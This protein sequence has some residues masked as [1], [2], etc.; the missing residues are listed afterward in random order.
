MTLLLHPGFHKTA[1]SWLQDVVFAE[2]R[3]FRSLM[4]HHEIDELL[5]RP[6]DLAF[7]AEAAKARIAGLR[8]GGQPGIVDVISSEILSGTMF[9]GSRES[10]RLADRLRAVA[11]DARILLTVRSQRSIMKSVYLQYVKRGGRMSIDEFLDYKPEPGYFWF[12]PSVLEFDRLAETYADRFGANNVIV[13]PQELLKSQQ[14]EYLG[15]LFQFA[16]VADL[17]QAKSITFGSERGVSPPAGGIRLMRAANI[18][19]RQPLNPE[20]LSSA[21]F[22]RRPFHKLAY[23]WTLGSDSADKAMH[24]S[25][26]SRLAGRYGESNRRLQRFAPVDLRSLGYELAE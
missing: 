24:D 11:G 17:A 12:E 14:P 7:D 10:L 25:I 23:A 2:K 15:L 9:T 3:L 1:T 22:L 16:G 13:L 6:H 18:L 20:G 21:A 19:G 5:V 26:R 8:E 4:T